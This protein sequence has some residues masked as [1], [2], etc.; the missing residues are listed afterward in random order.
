[1]PLY[2]YVCRACDKD[3]EALISAGRRDDGVVCPECGAARVARKISLVGA[4]VIKQGSR[5]GGASEPFSC[6]APSCCG[7][8]CGLPN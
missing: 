3:F 6:G 5:T 4:A 2:E 7:G 1:M 8:G